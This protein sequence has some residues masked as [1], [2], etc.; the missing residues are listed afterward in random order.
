MGN[1][2]E[3]VW[4]SIKLYVRSFFHSALATIEELIES[5]E[6]TCR[7]DPEFAWLRH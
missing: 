3:L 6:K 4:G 2:L 5:E 1:Y 7:N